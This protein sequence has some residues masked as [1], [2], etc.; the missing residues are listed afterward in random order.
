MPNCGNS[1]FWLSKLHFDPDGCLA[2][3]SDVHHSASRTFTTNQP[4]PAGARPEPTSPRGASGTARAYRSSGLPPTILPSSRAGWSS[5]NLAWRAC[6]NVPRE[7][8]WID[9]HAQVELAALVEPAEAVALRGE[10]AATASAVGTERLRARLSAR[11]RRSSVHTSAS[12]RA[13]R[14][15]RSCLYIR[16]RPFCA[17]A[18]RGLVLWVVQPPAVLSAVGRCFAPSSR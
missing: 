4:S 7:A 10:A 1:N 8:Q 18:L 12:S 13:A 17:C 3:F 5:V 11:A 15:M 9:P 2:P 14:S 6:R 16:T